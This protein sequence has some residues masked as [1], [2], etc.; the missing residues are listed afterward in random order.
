MSR[1][2]FGIFI[3]LHGLIHLWYVTLSL[4]LV[5]FQAEMG[6]TGK[7]WLFSALLGDG[8]TRSLATLLYGLAT[9]GFVIGGIGVFVQQEWWRPVVMGSAAFS[10]VL[11]LLFWDG[12]VQMLVE[13]GLIGFL[14]NAALL[15]A[16]FVFGWPSA[17]F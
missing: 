3:V 14:I 10:A 9:L 17:E 15:V 6:W 1:F 5:E 4:E 11:I 13:K 16:L 7:S 12:G 2:L 8:A